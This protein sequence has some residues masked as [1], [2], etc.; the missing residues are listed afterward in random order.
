MAE[1]TEVFSGQLNLAFGSIE[2]ATQKIKDVNRVVTGLTINLNHAAKAVDRLEDSFAKVSKTQFKIPA[3]QVAT[4][5]VSFKQINDQTR[6][7]IAEQDD[8]LHKLRFSYKNFSENDMARFREKFARHFQGML[9]DAQ[10]DDFARILNDI[11]ISL[12]STSEKVVS[13]LKRMNVESAAEWIK[14]ARSGAESG[15]RLFHDLVGGS[16]IVD[17]V[18]GIDFW[19]GKVP[20]IGEQN[21]AAFNRAFSKL[22][23]ALPEFAATTEKVENIGTAIGQIAPKSNT[24]IDQFSRITAS[25][26][27][28]SGG[29]VN[30]FQDIRGG[31]ELVTQGDLPGKIA[32][33]R[34]AFFGVSESGSAVARGLDLVGKLFISTGNAGDRLAQEASRISGRL[35]EMN[36]VIAEQTRIFSAQAK[37][38]GVQS[39]TL[40]DLQYQTQQVSNAY[41]N[42][43]IAIESGG[44]VESGQLNRIIAQITA[45]QQK[46]QILRLEGVIPTGSAAGEMLSSMEKNLSTNQVA[47]T[48]MAARM[49]TLAD[50]TEKAKKSSGGLVTEARGLGGI[51]AS[52]LG[53][54][55]RLTSSLN[56]FSQSAHAVGRAGSVMKNVLFGTFLGNILYDA[57][58]NI[59][60]AIQRIPA[61]IVGLASRAEETQNMFGAVFKEMAGE[62]EVFVDTLATGIGRDPFQ[63]KESFASFQAFNVGLGFTNK[64][65]LGLAETIQ[66]LTLDFASFYNISDQEAAQRF[67]SALSGS[68]EVLDKYGINIKEAA[69]EAESFR[70]G[71]NK[72]SADM[73]EQEKT[74]ARL[75]IIYNSMNAQGAI[76]DAVKTSESFANQTKQLTANLSQL[77]T[78][79]GTQVLPILS[80]FLQLVNQLFVRFGPSLLASIQGV[81]QG[82]TDMAIRITQAIRGA[83]QGVVDLESN[84]ATFVAGIVALFSGDFA[85]AWQFFLLTVDDAILSA[86]DSLGGFLTDA[87]DWGYSFVQQISDGFIAASEEALGAAIGYAT[88]LISSFFEPGSPPEEGPLS[89]IDKWGQ[90]LMDVFGQGFADSGDSLVQ[91]M[92][93]PLQQAMAAAS[94]IVAGDASNPIADKLEDARSNLQQVQ[95]RIRQ[96]E[97]Q[98]VVPQYLYDQ[99]EL[100]K[101][102]VKELEETTGANKDVTKVED[103]RAKGIDRVNRAGEGAHREAQER[104][105]K[106]KESAEDR[107]K[108]EL[109]LIEQK[110]RDGIISEKEYAAERLKIEQRLYDALAEEGKAQTREN[111]NNIKLYEAEVKRIQDAEK[112]SK[113]K[114]RPGSGLEIE[115]PDFETVLPD[116]GD[117][118]QGLG[119]G[120]GQKFSEGL[121]KKLDEVGDKIR[122]RFTSLLDQ[123]KIDALAALGRI[124]QGISDKVGSVFSPIVTKSKSAL[125]QIVTNLKGYFTGITLTLAVVLFKPLLGFGSSIGSVFG[126]VFNVLKSLAQVFLPQ[127][128]AAAQ[129]LGTFISPLVQRLLPLFNQGFGGVLKIVTRVGLRLG[130]FAAV[131]AIVVYGIQSNVEL[132]A[133][134]FDDFSSR[135]SGIVSR[136]TRLISDIYTAATSPSGLTG[137][138][139][140]M[141]GISQA[142]D[143][144]NGIVQSVLPNIQGIFAGAFNTIYGIIQATI[145]PAV[146]VIIG[147]MALMAGDS[148]LAEESFLAAWDSI[149]GGLDNIILGITQALY[150][151]FT[152]QFNLLGEIAGGFLERIGLTDLGQRV[153]EAI[154]GRGQEI[155]RG[156]LILRNIVLKAI[157]GKL[158]FRYILEAMGLNNLAGPLSS[159][160]GRVAKSVK[161]VFDNVILVISTAWTDFTNNLD[162]AG[163]FQILLGSFTNLQQSVARLR[164]T[165]ATAW[166]LISTA[167]APIILSL[168]T[169]LSQL[170][171]IM[172]ILWQ[173]ITTALA[174]AFAAITETFS[175]LFSG[176]STQIDWWVA[177][178]VILKTL[179]AI[180]GAVVVTAFA[181]FV[182]IINGVAVALSTLVGGITT[183]INGISIVIQGISTVFAGIALVISGLLAGD[184][185]LVKQGFATWATGLYNVFVGLWT[186]VQGLFEST[187]GTLLGIVSGFFTGVYG[188]FESMYNALVGESIVPDMV[189]GIIQWLL[190]LKDRGIA[191]IQEFIDTT[192]SRFEETLDKWKQIGKQIVD[193]L[194]QGMTDKKDAIITFLKNM[195]KDALGAFAGYLGIRSPSVLFAEL[196]ELSLEGFM[197]GMQKTLPGVKDV[198]GEVVD[199][200]HRQLTNQMEGSKLRWFEKVIKRFPEEIAQLSSMGKLT[201]DALKDMFSR[202]GV[203]FEKVDIR[204]N[205]LNKGLH[206]IVSTYGKLRSA[207]LEAVVASKWDLAERS[208]KF[209]TDVAEKFQTRLEDIRKAAL[210]GRRE[211]EHM[212]GE[213]ISPERLIELAKVLAQGGSFGASMDDAIR[214]AAKSQN[215]LNDALAQ[216]GSIQ[217][218][219][220]KQQEQQ[221]KLERLRE[222][223]GLID[224]IKQYGLDSS[225]ILQGLSLGID[226]SVSDVVAAMTRVTDA[227]VRQI[228]GALQ[229]RSPSKVLLNFGENIS[230]SLGLGI[231]KAGDVAVA[232][233]AEVVRGI[234]G[235]SYRL[236]DIR[237]LRSGPDSTSGP[238]KIEI[239][240]HISNTMDLGLVERRTTRAVIKAIP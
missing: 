181:V 198:L 2:Q 5:T 233:M 226:A 104:V 21:A 10:P 157:R 141:F 92:T 28:M 20:A 59:I 197:V 235:V 131:I 74:I 37:S 120:I 111:I 54:L 176:V 210:L 133:H 158:S 170:G 108:R 19:I 206:T 127:I 53:S 163:S 43:Q 184:F 228:Q 217:A 173:N 135:F 204:V 167:V 189:E 218:D 122:T 36:N 187:V 109:E 8:L 194:I 230:K 25:S 75:S 61:A 16:S 60:F 84:L 11:A 47:V 63:I 144:L 159:G 171:T 130:I 134:I 139:L 240:N 40:R 83:L 91:D 102:Q 72:S 88:D 132:L 162:L 175:G 39:S 57:I 160:F 44:K 85:G 62:A 117:K 183:T 212:T 1:T 182:G 78:S 231:L 106:E 14:F 154:V 112:E 188:V 97:S 221:A 138:G 225:E 100:A 143:Y 105:K 15:E 220:L 99:L 191:A 79:I 69:L 201:V 161:E 9:K 229:M 17:L 174:P 234:E 215:A 116:I 64:E 73:N 237:S 185:E 48:N 202:A 186:T 115:I 30:R 49:N 150:N 214:R 119:E 32:G 42:M 95:A 80:P 178:E 96:A 196:G 70:I 76:G 227:I 24:L 121:T 65:S 68:G 239:H 103:A 77:G 199:E 27:T 110:K 29:L 23:T 66:S 193:G 126:P 98:G 13:V 107:Y 71:I 33:I 145:I 31:I 22:G 6:K 149:K 142:L 232:G 140:V 224:T 200:V 26:T 190:S 153:R 45:L 168:Q 86:L 3:A 18:K 203:N 147:L 208:F 236:P 219:L 222:Q 81:T 55:S 46:Y 169:T 4:P 67:T 82:L 195:A 12:G 90:G 38:S 56:V 58:Q 41:R 180:I 172:L 124:N 148:K 129:Q 118:V 87:F 7:F 155:A 156:F 151:L 51:F 209:I 101:K 128:A 211:L 238:P 136:V 164:E 207:M 177:L 213:R 165:M 146:N 205:D 123:A 125:D 152:F 114:Q 93:R 192:R 137:I 94:N 34:Q 35:T 179:A 52:L 50:K 113:K 216:Q 223:I 89:T 166:A